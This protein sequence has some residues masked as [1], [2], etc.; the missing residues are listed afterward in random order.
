MLQRIY[1]IY[2]YSS[3]HIALLAAAYFFL[4]NDK[5]SLKEVFAIFLIT[6][7][8]YNL[9]RIIRIKNY[10]KIKKEPHLSWIS[11]NLTELLIAIAFVGF[12]LWL[13]IPKTYWVTYV[14]FG[15][16]FILYVFLRNYPL[17]KNL[18]IAF[19][20]SALPYLFTPVLWYFSTE[21]I[22]IFT[23][24]LFLSIL[25]DNKDKINPL[26]TKLG[27]KLHFLFLLFIGSLSI[28][29]FYYN[30]LD[31]KSTL[32]FFGLIYTALLFTIKSPKEWFYLI[33][34][35]SFILLPY[36]LNFS[37]SLNE[38]KQTLF[39]KFQ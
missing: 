14:I 8:A 1:R 31:W 26:K 7:I 23:H 18:L 29:L 27:P 22:F 30:S 10:E 21:N 16:I 5:K 32:L 28:F 4:E 35:D 37:I 24:F 33:V 17:V 3:I 15:I 6:W 2:F 20:W 9:L 36:L 11:T 39:L 12:I 25:Y 13:I 19:S 38:I 34:V